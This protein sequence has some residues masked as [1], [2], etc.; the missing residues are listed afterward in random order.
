[1]GEHLR[2]RLTGSQLNGLSI[3]LRGYQL[4]QLFLSDTAGTLLPVRV[5]VLSP[6]ECHPHH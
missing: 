1:M 3:R 4:R 5:L 6:L 2:M